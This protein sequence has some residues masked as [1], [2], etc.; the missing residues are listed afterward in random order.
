MVVEPALAGDH[1][2]GS[3]D[4]VGQPGVF[5]NDRRTGFAAGAQRQQRRADAARGACTGFIADRASGSGVQ[6]HRP[7]AQPLLQDANGVGVGTFLRPEHGRGTHRS[8]QRVLN[9]GSGDQLDSRQQLAGCDQAGLVSAAPVRSQLVDH[10]AAAVGAAAAAEPDHDP[11]RPGAHGG[12]DQLSHPPAVRG[13]R[14]LRSRRTAQQ[15]QATGL[16]TL[17]VGGPGRGRVEHPV[18]GHVL[19]QRAAHPE[20]VDLAESAGEHADEAGPTVG[21]R[22]QGQ[23]IVGAA[24]TPAARDRLGGLDGR[25]AVA[26]AVGGDQY[27]HDGRLGPDSAGAYRGTP[28]R[29]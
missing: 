29:K 22:R 20:G 18:R 17:D 15:S 21:L 24:A 8:E 1:E 7:V 19:G 14:G 5:G 13:Q 23:F 2:L 12:G 26:V 10:A 25:E 11:D 16:C 4:V 27:P 3:G 6:F 9:V 28:T